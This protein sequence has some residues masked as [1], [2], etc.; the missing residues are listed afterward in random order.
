MNR[1]TKVDDRNL[2][3]ALI[4]REYKTVE[5]GEIPCRIPFA[6]DEPISMTFDELV[7]IVSAAREF[8]VLEGTEGIS[9]EYLRSVGLFPLHTPESFMAM[10]DGK[11]DDS[12]AERWISL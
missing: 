12:Q 4:P 11:L 2:T 10:K 1:Y 7:Q 3:D 9:H 5:D 6:D 8:G